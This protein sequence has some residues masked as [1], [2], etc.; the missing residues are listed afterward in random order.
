MDN[1]ILELYDVDSTLTS[2]KFYGT[3]VNSVSFND[4]MHY[5]ET[6]HQLSLNLSV[7][8]LPVQCQA[9]A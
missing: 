9:S 5:P 2:G 7:K 1:K 8:N 6:Y 3:L 4:T